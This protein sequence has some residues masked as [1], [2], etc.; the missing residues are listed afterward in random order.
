MAPEK[1]KV[2]DLA[3]S[4]RQLQLQT[5]GPRGNLFRSIHFLSSFAE[6]A[7]TFPLPS[8]CI[9]LVAI[10]LSHFLASWPPYR[11]SLIMTMASSSLLEMIGIQVL[12][13]HL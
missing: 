5:R 3:A 10:S 13:V 4:L 9:A 7:G 12:T 2:N 8:T 6:S 1:Y 11:L